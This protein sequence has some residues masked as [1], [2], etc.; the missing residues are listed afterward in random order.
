MDPDE[1]AHLELEAYSLLHGD[2]TFIH[3]HVV[4]AWLAQHANERT[5]PIGLAFSL[6][7][8]HLHVEKGWTGREVQRAHST[9]AR[10]GGPWPP[11]ALPDERGTLTAKDVIAAS[12]GPER[13]RA[14]DTWCASV[15]EA[16]RDSHEEVEELLRK[17]GII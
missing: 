1:E 17:H 6:A 9:M 12:A 7:G 14:I 13:D 10:Q 4:D 8:L 2:P 11:I 3:Q 15:W 5:K 16:Y